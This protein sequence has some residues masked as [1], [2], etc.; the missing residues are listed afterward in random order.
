M[1][2]KTFGAA[3]DLTDSQIATLKDRMR[4]GYLRLVSE[5][6]TLDSSAQA[7]LRGQIKDLGE[8]L[9]NWMNTNPRVSGNM[10]LWVDEG[11]RIAASIMALGQPAG[12]AGVAVAITAAVVLGLAFWANRN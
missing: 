10:D 3:G 12:G 6:Q 11:N 8:A 9:D 2:V 4:Q 1:R 5:V 7:A